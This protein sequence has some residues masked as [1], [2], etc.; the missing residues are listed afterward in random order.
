MYMPI[1]AYSYTVPKSAEHLLRKEIAS[2]VD[3]RV[4]E[5]ESKIFRKVSTASSKSTA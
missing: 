2:T 5:R 3:I 4:L 1:H